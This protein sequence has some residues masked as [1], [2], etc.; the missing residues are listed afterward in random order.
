MRAQNV[1]RLAQK[2]QEVP[3][4]SRNCRRYGARRSFCARSPTGFVRRPL[5][6]TSK[7]F[8]VALNRQCHVTTIQLREPFGQ[9]LVLP[10]HVILVTL[11]LLPVLLPRDFGVD[12]L[13]LLP[14]FPAFR[15]LRVLPFSPASRFRRLPAVRFGSALI[16]SRRLRRQDLPCRLRDCCQG[17]ATPLRVG[18]IN[19]RLGFLLRDLTGPLPYCQRQ[20]SIPGGRLFSVT[21]RVDL[22]SNRGSLFLPSPSAATHPKCRF[23]SYSASTA[24]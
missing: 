24:S 14:F 22:A 1:R 4:K 21:N 13:S 20:L 16:N 3:R 12:L 15:G 6:L 11:P 19:P 9:V 7:P 2:G 8:R 10:A 17:L 23:S 18:G 5:L